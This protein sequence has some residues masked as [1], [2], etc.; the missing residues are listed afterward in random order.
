M[1][2]RYDTEAEATHITLRHADVAR[3]VEVIDSFLWVDV[4]EHGL[5]VGIEFLDTPADIDESALA[6][7]AERFPTTDT[8]SIKAA[9]AGQTLRRSV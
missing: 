2:V 7:V 6:R 4:D 9:L 1:I 3:T 8:A 5:P